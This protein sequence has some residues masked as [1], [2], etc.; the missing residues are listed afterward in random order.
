MSK[1]HARRITK[2]LTLEIYRLQ[3]IDYIIR[4][5]DHLNNLGPRYIYIYI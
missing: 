1:F 5:L 2:S 3:L 4:A